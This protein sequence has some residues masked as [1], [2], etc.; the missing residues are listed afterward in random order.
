MSDKQVEVSGDSVLREFESGFEGR[1]RLRDG[2]QR[3]LPG[4]A[5]AGR[6]G[7]NAEA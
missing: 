2:G 4:E 5:L 6:E 1:R 7:P 3:F